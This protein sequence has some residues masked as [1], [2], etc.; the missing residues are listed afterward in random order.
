MFSVLAAVL[1]LS[2]CEPVDGPGSGSPATAA[3]AGSPVA[4]GL[5]GT[6]TPGSPQVESTRIESPLPQV[7]PV[8]YEGAK[9]PV[10]GGDE[11]N[12]CAGVF[13]LGSRDI[14]PGVRLE[15]TG[16]VVEPA[17]Y[18]VGGAGCDGQPA[19]RCLGT[20]F[21]FTEEARGEDEGTC[22]IPVEPV[23]S[24]DET[25]D[26]V[27]TGTIVCA[28]GEAAACRDFAEKLRRENKTVPLDGPSR[29]VTTTPVTT[30][31]R[32]TTTTRSTTTT[33]AT[34]TES[35]ASSRDGS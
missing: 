16:A 5:P 35:A 26:L 27:V 17:V 12:R 24:S 32:A 9:L 34:R 2:G 21:A 15:V 25:V 10:G 7:D 14:P 1:L 13:Y 11:D 4:T 20:G 3:P 6:E 30:I 33:R 23:G 22:V 8:S 31:T 19:Q 18:G 28:P 29:P